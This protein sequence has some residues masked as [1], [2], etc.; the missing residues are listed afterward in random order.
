M[1]K[2]FMIAMA[3]IAF[4]ACQQNTAKETNSTTATELSSTA[5]TTIGAVA[6]PDAAILTFA[7]ESY[8]FGKIK[9]GESIHYDFKFK[10]TGKTPLIISN[11]VAT[12]GCTVPEP[13][14]DP[15]MPG[16]EGVIKVIFN[17]AGKMGVQDK[18]I[19]VTS[20]GNPA[21]NEVRLIGEVT[22]P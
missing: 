7:E 2:I 20:N 10:N 14:K 18:V 17:S 22:Q 5:E 9:Q 8:D 6:S 4:T 15:V 21:V 11:A 3:S 19:T 12:C 1:K 16:A 13:P